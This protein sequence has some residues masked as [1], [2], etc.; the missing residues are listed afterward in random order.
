MKKKLYLLGPALFG[1]M[2]LFADGAPA[3][4]ENSLL[5][6]V[7]FFVIVLAFFY[8]ILWRPEQKRRKKMQTLRDALKPGDKITAMGIVG[9]IAQVKEKTIV[10]QVDGAR[11]EMLKQAIS[12]IHK[13]AEETSQ[14]AIKQVNPA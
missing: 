9:E 12:E 1:A 3:A 2:P 14:E 13:P 11:I 6:T 5:R 10:V 8:L 4:Q 7:S